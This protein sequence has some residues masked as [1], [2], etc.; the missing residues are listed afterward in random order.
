METIKLAIAADHAGFLLKEEIIQYLISQGVKVKDFGTYSPE[1]VDYADYAHPLAEAVEK[2]EYPIGIT[3]CGSGN[4]INMTVNKHQGIRSA[5]CWNE[6]IA[7][8]ARFHND[9]NICALPA[10]FIT[11]EEAYR[12]IDVFLSTGFEG[13]R[14]KQRINKIPIKK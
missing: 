10:R 8:L 3:I 12:I 2:M 9:A 6:E 7:R 13:G 1:A 14:H 11:R 4:G 5:I